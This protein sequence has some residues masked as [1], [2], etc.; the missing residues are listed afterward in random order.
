MTTVIEEYADLPD[1]IKKA[2]ERVRS[3]GE[4]VARERELRDDLIVQAVDH[5]GI[6]AAAVASYARLTATH[7]NRILAD[8]SGS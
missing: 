1:R 3:L 6:T 5:A 2:A 8:A 4:Q 7:I